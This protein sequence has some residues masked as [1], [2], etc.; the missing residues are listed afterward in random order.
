MYSIGDGKRK[1]LY[2]YRA[3]ESL[4]KKVN[5]NF[6][7]ENIIRNYNKSY[8]NKKIFSLKNNNFIINKEN[9]SKYLIEKRKQLL[10]VNKKLLGKKVD[11]L[12]NQA[13][14]K[15]TNIRHYNSYRE[16]SK[17]DYS[18]EKNK[19]FPTINLKTNSKNNIH[20]FKE[21]IKNNIL[22][23]LKILFPQEYINS[24][25]RKTISNFSRNNILKNKNKYS[26]KYFKIKYITP[27]QI[28]ENGNEIQRNNKL[29]LINKAIT[30]SSFK[31]KKK[32]LDNRK[33]FNH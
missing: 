11:I 29:N 16:F 12:I 27:E 31:N 33:N 21:K 14:D 30:I 3:I 2:N 23:N 19:I 15:S 8:S 22:L 26:T 18:K 20:D 24:R 32:L 13:F 7:N 28:K 1:F 17:N 10:E 4:T 5:K 9:P 6:N 25:E